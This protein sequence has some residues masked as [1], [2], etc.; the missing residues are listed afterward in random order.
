MLYELGRRGLFCL[1]AETAHELTIAGLSRLPRL[2]GKVIGVDQPDQPVQV[3]GLD[4]RNPVG[5]AAGLDKDARAIDAWY[6]LGFGFIEVGTVTPRPQPG[7][8][9]PR[10]FRLTDHQAIINRMGFN[11]AGMAAVKRNIEKSRV[12]QS[13]LCPLGINIGKNFDTPVDQAV[14]DYLLGLRQF[15][16]LASYITVNISSPNT[17]GLRGLQEGQ[18]L[19]SLLAAISQLRDELADQSGRYVPLALKIAPDMDT[20]QIG[21]VADCLVEYKMDAVIATNTTLDRSAVMKSRHADEQG[22]LSGGPLQERSNEIVAL[23]KQRLADRMPIIGVGGITSGHDA[24]E[25]MQAG[26]DLLQIYTGFIY[27]GPELISEA[28]T[29]LSR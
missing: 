27:R 17:P 2:A 21:H 5:L 6:A 16:D 18:A 11:N 15:Y 24:L 10:L 12:F 29:E 7:N 9:K 25:K 26:A 19:E 20:E 13:G 8:P 23:L 22:G 1:D 14:D 3:M 28:L 4:F